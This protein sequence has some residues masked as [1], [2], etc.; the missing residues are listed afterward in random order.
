MSTLIIEGNA[1]FQLEIREK[2]DVIIFHTSLGCLE[3]SLWA[4][5]ITVAWECDESAALGLE[6]KF[7]NHPGSSFVTFW[8]G[9]IFSWFGPVV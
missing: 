9:V 7:F 1:K 3:F 8:F 5:E 2:K 6:T 4:E